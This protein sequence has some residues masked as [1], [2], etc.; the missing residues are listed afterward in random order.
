MRRFSFIEDSALRDKP[1]LRSRFR[2]AETWEA[3]FTRQEALRL[4]QDIQDLPV[5]Y[6]R[7]RYDL[8]REAGDP[9]LM[10]RR[11]AEEH[12]VPR[13]HLDVPRPR[14]Y[15]WTLAVAG[16]DRRRWQPG[17]AGHMD[18]RQLS[19][20]PMYRLV[21][22]PRAA[23]RRPPDFPPLS[24]DHRW[25]P[26]FEVEHQRRMDRAEKLLG[27][28]RRSSIGF[29]HPHRMVICLKRKARR[30]VLFARG[31]AAHASRSRRYNEYSYIRC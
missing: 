10:P 4:I 1:L 19:G 7:S 16:A 8:Y 2:A 17:T 11:V 22:R 26:G 6:P 30:A 27:I 23:W 9:F 13:P 3:E 12:F 24:P 14:R 28:Q 29:E 5:Y 21:E 15:P 18:A 31:L 20:S 25:W